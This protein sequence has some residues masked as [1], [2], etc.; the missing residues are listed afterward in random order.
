MWHP[1]AP[2]PPWRSPPSP[3]GRPPP[4]PPS[5]SLSHPTSAPKSSEVGPPQRG[6]G[7]GDLGHDFGMALRRQPLPPAT[8]GPGHY[9]DGRWT[10]TNEG[11]RPTPGMVG[12]CDR[13]G[14]VLGRC[15]QDLNSLG[16]RSFVLSGSSRL[17]VPRVGVSAEHAHGRLACINTGW[18]SSH[19]VMGHVRYVLGL[20][21]F[22]L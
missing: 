6:P 13:R 5:P 15:R 16:R 18:K 11:G 7:T 10:R 17:L 3:W 1:A 22:V 9:N 2:S 20:S 21:Q 8:G 19:P 14:R 4:P 12:E